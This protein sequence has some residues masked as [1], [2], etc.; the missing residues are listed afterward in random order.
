MSTGTSGSSLLFS[1]FSGLFV[2][3][4][5]DVSPVEQV[6]EGPLVRCKMRVIAQKWNDTGRFGP[7]CEL[8]FYVM[9]QE[10]GDDLTERRQKGIGYHMKTLVSCC[11]SMCGSGVLLCVSVSEMYAVAHASCTAA[12]TPIPIGSAATDPSH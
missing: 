12:S 6:L 8:F 5:Q 7:Y 2:I 11:V 10:P 3:R 1:G 4:S 9:R